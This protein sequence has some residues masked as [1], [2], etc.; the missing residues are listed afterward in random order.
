[1]PFSIIKKIKWNFNPPIASWWGGWW[2]R[3]I[4]MLKEM[5]RRILDRKSVNFEELVTILCVCEATINSRALTYTKDNSEDGHSR[6]VKVRTADGKKLRPIQRLNSLEM[7]SSE[8][9]PFIAQ[10]KD[11]STKPLRPAAPNVSDQDYSEDDYSSTKVVPD[12]VTKAGR[13]VKIPNRINL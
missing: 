7:S 5:L 13:R 11:K 6:I 2:E 4:C 10:Q 3:M 1:M 8:K 12:V 9:L